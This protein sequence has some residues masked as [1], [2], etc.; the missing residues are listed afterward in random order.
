MKIQ[1][2]VGRQIP[3][4]TYDV[5]CEPVCPEICVIETE[6]DTIKNLVLKALDDTYKEAKARDRR[7]WGAQHP[8]EAVLST[9]N[10][11]AE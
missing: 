7:G 8:Q 2:T 5:V 1:V 4:V 6:E 9:G 3:E 11:A 10:V